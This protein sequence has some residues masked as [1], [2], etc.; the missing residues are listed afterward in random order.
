MGRGL[1]L[2]GSETVE[3]RNH[4][5]GL[6]GLCRREHR[7]PAWRQPQLENPPILGVGMQLQVAY[8]HGIVSDPAC[9]LT[10]YPQHRTKSEI[11]SQ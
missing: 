8:T 3:Q 4:S 11:E 5:S 9:G 2:T 6:S 7:A 1:N 10:R